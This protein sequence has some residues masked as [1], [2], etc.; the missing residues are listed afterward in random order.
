MS[1]KRV[2]VTGLG[3]LTPVG[4]SVQQMWDSL[5]KGVSGAGLI[6][7]FDAEKFKCRIACEL[8]GFDPL[9]HFD[10]KE[11]RKLDP[12]TQYGK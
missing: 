3:A 4:S 12:F 7:R 8:K 1:F 6:T 10:R 5:L 2:V 9:C 11:V